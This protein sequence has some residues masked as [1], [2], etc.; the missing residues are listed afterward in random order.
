VVTTARLTGHSRGGITPT[1][2]TR[3]LVEQIAARLSGSGPGEPTRTQHRGFGDLATTWGVVEHL[4]VAGIVDDVVGP[5]RADAGASVG[6]YLALAAAN[7]VVAPCS[8]L[9]FSDWWATTTT[10]FALGRQPRTW[11]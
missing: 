1:I 11:D 2:G 4:G 7:R 5:R 10:P 3:H 9:G 8:K 6:T